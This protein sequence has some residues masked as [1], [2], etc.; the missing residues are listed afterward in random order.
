MLEWIE[1]HEGLA[2]WVQAVFSVVAI[3]AGFAVAVW[4]QRQHNKQLRSE[5]SLQSRAVA[6]VIRHDLEVLM[7]RIA[8]ARVATD[9]T[10]KRVD[11]P[12]WLTDNIGIYHF[13]DEVGARVL[14]IVAGINAL[15]A[16]ISDTER[17]G[18]CV[19]VEEANEANTLLSYAQE[20][21]ERVAHKIDQMFENAGA[22]T[23][24]MTR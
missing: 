5:R 20:N 10:G 6:I 1:G 17:M 11:L 2:A 13:M 8:R 23:S 14:T 19:G 21:C 7:G 16:M 3:G 9:L 22:A 12:R 18:S 24:Q 15:N 4:Q